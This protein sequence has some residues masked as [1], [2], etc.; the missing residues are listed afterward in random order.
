MASGTGGVFR[1]AATSLTFRGLRAGD[2]YEMKIY[3]ISIVVFQIF[4]TL[5]KK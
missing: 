5:L 1:E 3:S 2:Q 4:I